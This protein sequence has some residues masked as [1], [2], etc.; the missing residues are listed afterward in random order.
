MRARTAAAYALSFSF[1]I[2]LGAAANHFWITYRWY[3][4]VS[5]IF[6]GSLLL[7]AFIAARVLSRSSP[8]PTGGPRA[9]GWPAKT[10]LALGAATAVLYAGFYLYDRVNLPDGPDIVL[11]TI[12]TLRADHLGCYGYER[13]TSPSIDGVAEEGVLFANAFVP[14]GLTWPSLSSIMTS[15]YPVNHGVRNNGQMLYPS[16]ISMAEV[17]KNEGYRCG[18]FLAHGVGADWRGFDRLVEA[19]YQDELITE[20]AVEWLKENR[21]DKL[22]LW[23]HY[24]EPHKPYQPPEPYDR[25]FDPDYDGVMN[26]SAEQ[27]KGIYLNKMVLEQ[28]DYEH[29]ISLYDGS[30]LAVDDRVKRVLDALAE[31]GLAEKSLL[32]ISADHGEDLYQHN[33]YFNHSASIYD[34]S[35]HVP[36][37]IRLP[38]AD[39]Q[40]GIV[41]EVVESIDIAPTILDLAEVSVP[42]QFEG[43][44]LLPLIYADDASGDFGYAFSEWEDKILSVRTDRHRYI[45]NPREFHPI[46]GAGATY[47]T[48]PIEREELYDCAKDAA[49]SRNI[50]SEDPETVERLMGVLLEWENF[51]SWSGGKGMSV[52][53]APEHVK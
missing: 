34:S 43:S 21:D 5:L 33:F 19:A 30:I 38:G 52:R 15:L 53:E 9:A 11:I 28:E 18:A 42:D 49:E 47:D 4:C 44:S 24:F 36:L 1:F 7:F 35:L 40:K 29:I 50:V 25:V 37:I 48:Y 8:V 23:M 31:L 13:A 22:F 6:D 41:E 14:R 12:E 2:C 32:I 51:P 17:L 45:Y 27:L 16:V 46:C 3:H 20:E 10:V 26:G 39:E